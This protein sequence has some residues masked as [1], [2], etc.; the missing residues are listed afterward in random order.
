MNVKK[1][2]LMVRQDSCLDRAGEW[3]LEVLGT[4]WSVDKEA[5]NLHLSAGVESDNTDIG[6][7]EGLGAVGDLANNLGAISAAEHWELPH[8]P[9]TVIVV[10][11]G[12]TVLDTDSVG[13]SDV[14][15][16]WVGEL[17][18]R[19]P[20]VADHVINLLDDVILGERWEEGESLKELVVEWGPD[21]HVGGGLLDGGVGD[22]DAL[23]SLARGALDRDSLDRK[24]VV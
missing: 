19:S 24:S 1:T 15:I 9:V 5:G 18:A 14:S 17:E 12:T 11:T 7:W 21:L 8:S 6:I 3:C 22:E 23:G 4:W 10:I 2:K 13:V 20:S 16:L